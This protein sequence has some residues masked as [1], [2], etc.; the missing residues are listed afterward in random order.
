M[1]IIIVNQNFSSINFHLF[2]LGLDGGTNC[3]ERER[4]INAFNTPNSNVKLFLLST[5]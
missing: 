5:R 1:L 4:L 3:L 2:Y